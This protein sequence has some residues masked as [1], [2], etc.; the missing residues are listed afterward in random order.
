MI[1][2]ALTQNLRSDLLLHQ[3]RRPLRL[4]A[5]QLM[6]PEVGEQGVDNFAIVVGQ[7]VVEIATRFKRG[8][9]QG[10]LTEAVDGEDRRLVKTMHRQQ[11]TSVAG[12]IRVLGMQFIEQ[13]VVARSLFI[14]RQQLG[15][16]LTNALAQFGGGSSGK[17]HHQN[18]ADAELLLQQQAR[19]QRGQGP[20][21]AGAGAGLD[22]RATGEAVV[23]Q[24]QAGAAHASS[25]SLP[26]RTSSAGP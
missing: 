9:L 20:G 6:P 17:G 24:V 15:Q 13:G 25:S 21:F 12:S 14:H 22:Q 10:A 26:C 18:L 4:G 16:A 23:Q 8:V 5:G 11:Q 3:K 7:L 1:A 19:V 2:Q